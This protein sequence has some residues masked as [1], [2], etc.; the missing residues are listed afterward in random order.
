M[1]QAAKDETKDGAARRGR[2]ADEKANAIDWAVG[3]ST[4]LAGY[5]NQNKARLGGAGAGAAGFVVGMAVGGPIGAVAGAFLASKSASVTIDA[6]DK[7][8]GKKKPEN[9]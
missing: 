9:G 3:A 8:L 4:D 2:S 5:T 6:V 1:G 7:R